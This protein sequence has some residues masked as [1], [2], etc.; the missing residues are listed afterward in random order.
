MPIFESLHTQLPSIR[1][2]GQS[3]DDLINLLRYNSH[4][5]MCL[6]E[7]KSRIQTNNF[8]LHQHLPYISE[9]LTDY[10]LFSGLQKFL[11]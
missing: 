3:I 11:L 9:S 7:D 8:L 6:H 5:Y 10:L 4:W 1:L 2:L